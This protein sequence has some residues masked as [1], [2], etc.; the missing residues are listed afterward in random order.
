MTSALENAVLEEAAK[1]EGFKELL[2]DDLEDS[3]PA[4]VLENIRLNLD[5]LKKQYS[6]L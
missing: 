5:E 2:E 1:F 6:N 4:N 3:E